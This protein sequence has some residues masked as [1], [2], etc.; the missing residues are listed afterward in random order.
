[1]YCE[2]Q[3]D[4]YGLPQAGKLA[5]NQLVRQLEPHVYAPCCHTPGLWRHKWR[6]VLLSLV[7]DDFGVKNV[8]R[9]QADHIVTTLRKYY[10]L[11]TD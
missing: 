5:Y 9:A 11:K 1:M 7:V 8:G 4:M 2:I 10:T 3:R 6:P